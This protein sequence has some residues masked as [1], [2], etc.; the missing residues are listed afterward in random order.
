MGFPFEIEKF[1]GTGKITYIDN[2]EFK[3]DLSTYEG[4]SGSPICLNNDYSDSKDIGIHKQGDTG[5]NINIGTFIG[6]IL[7]K[8]NNIRQ[9]RRKFVTRNNDSK[10]FENILL[11]SGSKKKRINNNYPNDLHD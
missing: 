8:L 5:N 3:H 6:V 10:P 9:N 7:D 1:Q 2:Y 11:M 4:S